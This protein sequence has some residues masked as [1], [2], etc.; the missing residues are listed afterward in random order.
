MPSN[1]RPCSW[2][3]SLDVGE[4]VLDRG[5]AGRG[6]ADAAAGG[7]RGD[8]HPRA[9]ECLAGAGRS[10]HGQDGVVE[11]ERRGDQRVDVLAERAGAQRGRL[12][13][14]QGTHGAERGPSPASTE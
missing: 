4:Q 11:A 5:V 7:E 14:Q 10:L 2:R 12:A 6:D 1:V 9:A 3:A 13:A 8:D